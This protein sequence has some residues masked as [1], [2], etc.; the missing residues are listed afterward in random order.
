MRSNASDPPI[1][2]IQVQEEM[3]EQ[4]FNMLKQ[5]IDSDSDSDPPQLHSS[6]SS[7]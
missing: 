2:D 7:S 6:S 3:K 4:S 5:A 1:R